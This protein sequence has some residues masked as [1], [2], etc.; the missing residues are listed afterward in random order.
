MLWIVRTAVAGLALALPF[1]PAPASVIPQARDSDPRVRPLL[2]E[3]VP[4]SGEIELAFDTAV[5]KT[6]VRFSTSLAS[7]N[8]LVR[9]FLGAP[10]VHT[11][12]ADY[13]FGGR[14]PVYRPALV[15]V[16]LISDEYKRASSQDFPLWGVDPILAVSLGDTVARYPL[17]IAQMVEEWLPPAT[18]SSVSPPPRGD[19]A[20]RYYQQ[21][22]PRE[23]HIERTATAW[24]PICDFLGLVS[25]RNVHGTVAG[26]EFDLNDGV[27]SGLRQFA[28]KMTVAAA[29]RD[30]I[31]CR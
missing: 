14:A 26:L 13:E 9:V 28:A 19:D 2:S 3:A 1:A 16:S 20:I 31:N 22:L 11:L 4:F 8:V 24:I 18:T 29:A 6:R 5:N 21:Q 12:I 23:I 30:R 7:G 17:G 25:A 10:A 27:V 15:R